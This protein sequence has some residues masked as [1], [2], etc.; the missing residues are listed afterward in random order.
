MGMMK[1]ADDQDPVVAEAVEEIHKQVQE[2]AVLARAAQ[3]CVD[4][5]VTDWV[6]A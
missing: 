6:T 5:N 3:T 2:T 1:R 4:L